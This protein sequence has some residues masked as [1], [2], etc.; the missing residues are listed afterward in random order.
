MSKRIALIFGIFCLALSAC[1]G[2]NK[3]GM[4]D[5]CTPKASDAGLCSGGTQVDS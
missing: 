3:G 1:Q 5:E 2:T 4:D